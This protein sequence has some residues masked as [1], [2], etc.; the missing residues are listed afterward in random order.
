VTTVTT[1][2]FSGAF[3]GRR[4][5]RRTAVVAAA[6]ATLLAGCTRP[7]PKSTWYA[8][9]AQK[10]AP[11]TPPWFCNAA[12][13]GTPLGGHGN[14]SHVN[15]IY[16]G[17]VK[18]PLSPQDCAKLTQQLD[19][20]WAAVKPWDTRAKGEAA[21][22]V[23]SAEYIAGLGTHH[24]KGSQNIMAGL[25]NTKFDHRKPMF[26]I[27]GG[28]GPE[29]PLVGVA[30]A[31]MGGATPPEGYAGQND[32]WHKHERIC[33][34]GKSQRF[35]PNILAGAEQIP[36]EECTALGGFNA[37]VP[38]GMWL[39][40]LWPAPPYQYKLDIFASG[41]NCLMADGVAP[42]SD[43][44]WDIAHRDPSL[45]MPPGAG[46]DEHDGGHDH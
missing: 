23:S 32:W 1:D 46:G 38:G 42:D 16:E 37:P 7:G 34:D 25:W 36:D 2:R 39:L 9:E 28:P 13:N 3:M 33:L 4:A 31:L 45:G 8:D 14:G 27:Y 12:G 30:F 6:A 26:L 22:W 21:G 19:E 5:L 40:H 15:P 18:G 10:A 44:C 43:P 24:V 17:K 20:T 11:G 29:A 41:H 35:P